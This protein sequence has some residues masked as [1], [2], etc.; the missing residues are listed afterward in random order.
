MCKVEGA[1]FS[2]LSSQKLFSDMST[3]YVPRMYYTSTGKLMIIYASSASPSVIKLAVASISG[4]SITVNHTLSIGSASNA[5]GYSNIVELENNRFC[6]VCNQSSSLCCFSVISLNGNTLSLVASNSFDLLNLRSNAKGCA[7]LYCE[8]VEYQKNRLL[9]SYA[10]MY[11]SSTM[12]SANGVAIAIID[13]NQ[14]TFYGNNGL[15]EICRGTHQF[16]VLDNSTVQLY[17]NGSGIMNNKIINI[18]ADNTISVISGSGNITVSGDG[19][20]HVR[21]KNNTY[22]MT[23]DVNYVAVKNGSSCGSISFDRSSASIENSTYPLELQTGQ[24][25]VMGGSYSGW[26]LVGGVIAPPKVKKSYYNNE[27]CGIALTSG[28]PG[29]AINVMLFNK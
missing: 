29:S 17:Y 19:G 7:N 9:F 28:S 8:I 10:I 4:N 15:N 23:S 5:G 22:I 26:K 25:V 3:N 11:G 18:A 6:I 27:S 20:N 1:T 16:H 2:Q 14:I 12:I 21:L 13:G 24:V